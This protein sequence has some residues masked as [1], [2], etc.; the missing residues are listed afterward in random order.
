MIKMELLIRHPQGKPDLSCPIFVCDICNKKIER[1]EEGMYHWHEEGF[2]PTDEP[3]MIL[4]KK[5]CSYIL[6]SREKITPWVELRELLGYLPN[7]SG[8]PWAKLIERYC[9]DDQ[10][11]EVKAQVQKRLKDI[12]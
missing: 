10:L 4:H 6:E 11:R 9:P 8:M 1:I 5:P 2:L 12:S 7:N 3:I